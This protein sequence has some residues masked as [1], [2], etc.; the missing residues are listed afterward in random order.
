MTHSLS[1]HLKGA[2]SSFAPASLKVLLPWAGVFGHSLA[3]PGS[4]PGAVWDKAIPR[5]ARQIVVGCGVAE[6]WA[7]LPSSTQHWPFQRCIS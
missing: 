5:A 4:C 6:L 7:W 3:V 1:S 2:R